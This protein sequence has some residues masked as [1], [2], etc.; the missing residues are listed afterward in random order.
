H[1]ASDLLRPFPFPLVGAREERV[2]GEAV[3]EARNLDERELYKDLS[4]LIRGELSSVEV[5]RL[6]SREGFKTFSELCEMRL[7]EDLGKVRIG[8]RD[9][10]TRI[11]RYRRKADGERARAGAA[12]PPAASGPTS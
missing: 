4:R 12:A 10:L 1:G 9:I 8:T 2:A 6:V 3:T 7:P 11:D 5:K